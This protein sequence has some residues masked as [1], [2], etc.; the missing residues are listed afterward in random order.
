MAPHASVSVEMQFIASDQRLESNVA[1][2]NA[3]STLPK[4]HRLMYF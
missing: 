4:F 1:A 2:T 3:S